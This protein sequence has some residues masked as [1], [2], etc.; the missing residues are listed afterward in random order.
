MSWLHYFG[1][2]EHRTGNTVLHKE[3]CERE[4]GLCSNLATLCSQDEGGE[5]F[6]DDMV[7]ISSLYV[8]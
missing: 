2:Q 6:R 4:Q 7:I 1:R 3:V 5:G 8:V